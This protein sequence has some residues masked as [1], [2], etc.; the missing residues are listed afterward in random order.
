[1]WKYIVCMGLVS[2]VPSM[3]IV[4]VLVGWGVI[5]EE[6]S[7]NFGQVLHPAAEFVGMVILSPIVETLLMSFFIWLL[8]FT[9]KRRVLLAMMSAL[10]WAGLHSLLAP[11]WGLGVLWPFFVI[12]CSYLAWREKSWFHAIL[13]ASCV[14]MLQN[15]IPATVLVLG[16]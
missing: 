12:S 5:N 13:A 7:P 15:L 4:A 16:I 8:S 14:H 10:V 6:T 9:T 2:F 11:A 1:M 3:A